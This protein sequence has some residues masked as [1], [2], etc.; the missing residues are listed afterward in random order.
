M[1]QLRFLATILAATLTFVLFSCGSGG[2]KKT[3]ETSTDTSKTQPSETTAEKTPEST[4]PAHIV[5]VKHRVANYSKWK[6]S[7]DADDSARRAAGLSNYVLARGLGK[8]SNIVMVV[9]KANNIIKAKE[10]ASSTELSEVMKKAGVMGPPTIN[11]IDVVMDDNS[12]ISH[13]DRLLVTHKVK[14]WDIWKTGFDSHKQAR[15][16]AGLTDR[17]LGHTS[18]DTHNVSIVLA[19]S[20]MAKAKAFIASKDLKDKMT[21]AGVEG[22]PAFFFYKIVQVYQ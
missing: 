22:P 7:Y 15:I 3:E 13:T 20:D 16:D 12:Q 2:E 5:T 9:L 18:G 17:A 8:D 14:D 21:E 11:Y 4:T 10:F 1:K 6:M 19:V